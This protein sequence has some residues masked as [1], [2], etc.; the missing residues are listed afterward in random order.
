MHVSRSFLGIHDLTPE[1]RILY[2]SPSVEYI[3]GYEIEEVVG[4]SFFNHIYQDDLYSIREALGECVTGDRAAIMVHCRMQKKNGDSVVCYLIFTTVYDILVSIIGVHKDTTNSEARRRAAVAISKI[5][6]SFESEDV[7][8]SNADENTLPL[9]E[10]SNNPQHEL[11][12]LFI[13]NRSSLSLPILYATSS[14]TQLTQT[15]PESVRGCSFWNCLDRESLEAAQLTIRRV[16]ENDSVA[17]LQFNWRDPTSLSDGDTVIA[18]ATTRRSTGSS[19]SVAPAI[20]LQA[21]VFSTS[22]GLVM[23]IR[24]ADSSEAW[25]RSLES[26]LPN[27]G[28]FSS[29][30]NPSFP[31][32]PPPLPRTIL[33]PRPE[34]SSRED[35]E[36]HSSSSVNEAEAEV[37]DEAENMSS[38][39]ESYGSQGTASP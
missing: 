28:S 18:S 9:Y 25:S 31:M 16:Q 35:S 36:N 10:V 2:A 15:T 39:L 23:I 13:I 21:I 20:R 6:N 12:T 1:S 30:W 17:Y 14:L 38:S 29:A 24:L 3:M 34:G 11:R 4:T 32:L 5:F 27:F 22:D 33:T 7:E 8:C 37:E 19:E 26:G